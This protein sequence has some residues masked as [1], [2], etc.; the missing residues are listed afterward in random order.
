MIEVWDFYS[1]INSIGK[2]TKVWIFPWTFDPFH[3]WHIEVIIK[4]KTL[5]EVVLVHPWNRNINKSKTF[6]KFWKR[7]HWI[8]LWIKEFN[9]DMNDV[10]ILL[11]SRYQNDIKAFNKV[12][13]NFSWRVIQAL[14]PDVPTKIF[15]HNI[16]IPGRTPWKSSNEIKANFREWKLDDAAKFLP[17][18][19]FD[20]IINSGH[21]FL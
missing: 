21:I 15:S 4:L 18:S 19:V 8:E 10:W 9:T 7:V 6:S 5:V 20:D 12:V 17:K 2:N 14:W 13:E 11:D 1:F 16:V 3:L